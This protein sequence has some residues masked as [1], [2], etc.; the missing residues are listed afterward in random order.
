MTV[1]NLSDI[2]QV[3]VLSEPEFTYSAH[4]QGLTFLH[5]GFRFWE[6]SFRA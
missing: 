6:H 5:L 2:A 1:M 4:R 3:E